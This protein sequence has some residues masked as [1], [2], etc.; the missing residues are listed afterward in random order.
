MR[1][2]L[3][4]ARKDLRRIARE[5]VALLVWLG[6]P[7][8]VAV[9]L[10]V[11]FRGGSVSPHGLLLI[12][13]EDQS[14]LSGAIPT[15][16]T[17]GELGKMFQVRK[18][19]QAAGRRSM[20]SGEASAL[21]VIPKGFGDAILLNG[22]SRLQVVT[23]PS[24]RILPQIVEETVSI[25]ADGAFYLNAVAGEQLRLLARPS[26]ISDALA[27]GT[28]IEFNRLGTSL[29]KYVDPP[30]IELESGVR[31]A[32][33]PGGP[34][35]TA[36]F[37]PG[38]LAMSVLFLSMGLSGDIWKERSSHT[39]RRL[40]GLTVQHPLAAALWA[41]A[42]AAVLYLFLV[43]LQTFAGSERAAN[44]LANFCVFPFAMLGGAFFPFEMMPAWMAAGDGLRGSVSAGRGAAA[45][46]VRPVRS[47][48]LRDALF[49]ARM[50][51]RL[52]F[53]SRITWLWAFVMPVVFFYFIGTV[54][55]GARLPRGTR[56]RR[57]ATGALPAAAA[58]AGRFHRLRARR[59]AGK[60]EPGARRVRF[61]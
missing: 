16:F 43:W 33:Q 44:L 19:E 20:Q 36:M 56:G 18:V 22:R 27:A 12:A 38:M 31:Q 48:A 57:R 47:G 61:Q 23:N 11:I 42:A 14:L 26:S 32:A 46:E 41:V 50:D 7:V 45:R 21:L 55:G 34:N 59:P 30:L 1:F 28:A 53:R 15:M 60:G 3:A 37:F 5:P 49:L 9:L 54:T 2:L 35:I 52:M 29:R 6:I 13:D 58:R 10:I 4:G 40:L 51:L 24:Q 8:F 17:Q 39:L 25:L